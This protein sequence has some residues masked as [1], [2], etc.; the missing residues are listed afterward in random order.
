MGTR[1][2]PNPACRTASEERAGSRAM[3]WTGGRVRVPGWSLTKTSSSRMAVVPTLRGLPRTFS[4][5]RVWS[6]GQDGATG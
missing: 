6:Q 4:K 2:A 3:V 5:P 1:R